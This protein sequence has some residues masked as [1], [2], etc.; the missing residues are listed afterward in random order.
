MGRFLTADPYQASGGPANPGSWNRYAY[1]EGDPVGFH[2]PAGLMARAPSQ[3]GWANCG[4][5]WIWDASLSGPCTDESIGG[6]GIGTGGGGGGGGDSFAPKDGAR[7][8]LAK[9]PCYELLGFASA[10]AAQTWFD[11]RITFYN[12]YAGKLQV[13]RQGPIPGTPAPASTMGWG[14]ININRDYSWSD[15]SKVPTHNGGTYDYLRYMNRSLGTNMTSDQLGALI[16]IHELGHQQ[17]APK[18]PSDGESAK[19]KRDIYDKC[20]M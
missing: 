20:I 9:E 6:G 4:P 5:N 11:N 19:E 1:V 12:V 7:A 14:Q 2:D 3:W 8:D 10:E 15:F 13:G 18:H 17:S 16:I